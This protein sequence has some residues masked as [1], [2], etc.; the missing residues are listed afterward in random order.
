LRNLTLVSIDRH[1][2]FSFA[3]MFRTR[4]RSSSIESFRP[5]Q[6]GGERF[7]IVYQ[8]IEEK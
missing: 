8:E 2:G 7:S 5:I 6:S 3:Q 4:L 1:E